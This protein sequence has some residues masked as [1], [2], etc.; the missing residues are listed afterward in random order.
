MGIYV[1]RGN[2]SFASVL[3]S[4]VYV[5]KTGLPSFEEHLNRYDGY[6]FRRIETYL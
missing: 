1:N 2:E 3:K 4:Q 6:S 5:D